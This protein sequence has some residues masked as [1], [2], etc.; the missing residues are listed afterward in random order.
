MGDGQ[1]EPGH[2]TPSD[3]AFLSYGIAGQ[4]GSERS[5]DFPESLLPAGYHLYAGGGD[6][7]E[8]DAFGKQR[9]GEQPDREL[10]RDGA[11]GLFYR[12][13]PGAVVHRGFEYLEG[14]RILDDVLPCGIKGH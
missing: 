5:R 3:R 2:D 9:T 4:P 12:R 13:E 11:T 7:L 14:V 1:D 6:L 10:V 8:P